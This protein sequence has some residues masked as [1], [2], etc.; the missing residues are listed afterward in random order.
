M[1]GEPH[2]GYRNLGG[3]E[4]ERDATKTQHRLQSGVAC[5]KDDKHQKLEEGALRGDLT[6]MAKRV[7]DLVEAMVKE[8]AR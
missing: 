1:K 5:A 6:D 7:I 2:H 4:G 8:H 3:F